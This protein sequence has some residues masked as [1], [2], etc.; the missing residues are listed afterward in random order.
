MDL[1]AGSQRQA[2]VSEEQ[3]VTA[4]RYDD[5]R[6]SSWKSRP[7]N[8]QEEEDEAETGDPVDF[9]EPLGLDSCACESIQGFRLSSR[10]QYLARNV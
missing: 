10:F 4:R 8:L 7:R 2:S 3:A 9:V 5:T 6:H 1:A